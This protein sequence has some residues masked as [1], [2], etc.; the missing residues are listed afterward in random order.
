MTDEEWATQ[1]HFTALG[2]L[3]PCLIR[4]QVDNL[5][6]YRRDSLLKPADPEV[7]KEIRDLMDPL[8]PTNQFLNNRNAIEAFNRGRRTSGGTK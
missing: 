3:Y 5:I 8:D 4:L 7:P 2:M 6:K 1:K